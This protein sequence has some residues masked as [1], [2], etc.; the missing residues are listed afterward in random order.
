MKA[1]IP[2]HL[3]LVCF[4]LACAGCISTTF[5][6]SETEDGPIQILE[7]PELMKILVDPVYEDLK[8]WIEIPPKGRKAWRG[9]YVASF[10]LAEL[11]NLMYSRTGEEYTNN[12][13]W[14][15]LVTE[16]R[17]IT[18]RLA[19]SVREQ[20]DYETLKKNYL[21]VVKSCNKCHEVFPSEEPPQIDVPRAW[22][23]DD[24]PSSPDEESPFY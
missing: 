16:A 14:T 17:D 21:A 2:S 5:A 6:A 4:L 3:L 9:L 23:E 7:T 12:A 11:T 15:R 13:E 10:S 8:D 24:A 20:A 1:A 18:V 22:M 19:E